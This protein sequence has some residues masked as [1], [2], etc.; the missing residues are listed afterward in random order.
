[1]GFACSGGVES[2]RCR[3][4]DGDVKRPNFAVQNRISFAFLWK[5]L[6]LA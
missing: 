5:C 4:I 2:R 6:T 3:G 1:M